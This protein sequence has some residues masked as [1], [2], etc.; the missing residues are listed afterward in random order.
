M[1]GDVGGGEN[2]A[3]AAFPLKWICE[4]AAA[5]GLRFYG[6]HGEDRSP[7]D[8]VLHDAGDRFD[9]PISRPD[10]V[11]AFHPMNWPLRA[12]RIWTEKKALPSLADINRLFHDTVMH[13]AQADYLRPRY[14][15]G[16][17]RAFRAALREWASKT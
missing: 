10:F 9:D 4:G 14:R 6:V 15:P 3:L 12:R 2:S 11:K 13:R 8:D 5:Q 1:H 16:G 7:L 17:L